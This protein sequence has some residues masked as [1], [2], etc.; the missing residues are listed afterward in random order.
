MPHQTGIGLGHFMVVA[1]RIVPIHTMSIT[2]TITAMD[3]HMVMAGPMAM[4]ITTGMA[5]MNGITTVI[6][7]KKAMCL[8]GRMAF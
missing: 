7:Q 8:T 6:E 1:G 5:M 2:T 3:D 4:G